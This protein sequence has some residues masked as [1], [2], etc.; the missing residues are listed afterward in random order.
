MAPLLQSKSAKRLYAASV[1]LRASL[2]LAV[3]VVGLVVVWAW[4]LNPN[5]TLLTLT[6]PCYDVPGFEGVAPLSCQVLLLQP[7]MARLEPEILPEA[8]AVRLWP[9]NALCASRS[10]NVGSGTGDSVALDDCMLA[11]DMLAQEL[12]LDRTVSTFTSGVQ[13]HCRRTRCL[14]E[15]GIAG[16]WT[17]ELLSEASLRCQVVCPTLRP[18]YLDTVLL[19][20]SIG[21]L[22]PGLA[23]HC[24]SSFQIN[25]ASYQMTPHQMATFDRFEW[26]GGLTWLFT[27]AILIW[28][29][30]R[31]LVA[32]LAYEKHVGFDREGLLFTRVPALLVLVEQVSERFSGLLSKAKTLWL[33]ATTD[34][35]LTPL[36]TLRLH[37]FCSQVVSF[38]IPGLDQYY[39]V[40][41]IMSYTFLM[42][43]V[44]IA[45]IFLPRCRNCAARVFGFSFL[46]FLA[47]GILLKVVDFNNSGFTAS[48]ILGIDPALAFDFRVSAATAL[49]RG[50]SAMRVLLFVLSI[51]D[52]SEDL[53]TTARDMYLESK[54][55]QDA[56]EEPKPAPNPQQ[57]SV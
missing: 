17:S 46:P 12:T 15:Q 4:A 55:A 26:D 10:E 11:Q 43:G 25:G 21:E 3:A 48:L 57:L 7:G 13:R 50:F 30:L 20:D 33:T 32:V 14:A 40:I 38:N 49:S 41:G 53:E 45:S 16:N 31:I 52:L 47:A 27:M 22:F 8:S 19:K 42:W 9:P 44:L 23:T 29:L 36:T 56:Q 39:W 5:N 34:A 24:G 2:S 6:R 28:L 1:C 18:G 35:L 54:F 37:D 51:W